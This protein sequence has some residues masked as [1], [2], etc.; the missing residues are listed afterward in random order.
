MAELAHR[1]RS[2]VQVPRMM[3]CPEMIHHELHLSLSA[4]ALTAAEQREHYGARIPGEPTTG[5]SGRHTCEWST[6]TA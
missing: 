1:D 4:G 3:G 6:C 2:H 5:R